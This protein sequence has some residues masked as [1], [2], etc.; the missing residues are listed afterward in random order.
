[1]SQSLRDDTYR[2]LP[3]NA[4][5]RVIPNFLDRQYHKRMFDE[6]LA[7]VIVEVIREKKLVI[8]VSNY[9]PVKRAEIGRR[10]LSSYSGSRIGRLL[11]VGDGPDL[12]AAFPTCTR[13]WTFLGV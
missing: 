11:L 10:D 2:Q 4:D 6:S 1:M 3:V 13:M 8:H 9:R 12:P 7:R 5:I